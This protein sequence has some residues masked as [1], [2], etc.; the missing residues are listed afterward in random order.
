MMRGRLWK[1]GDHTFDLSQHGLIMGVLNVTPDSFSDGGNFFDT[2]DAAEH[3]LKMAAEGAHIVDV[4]GE[5]T[6]PGAEAVTAEEELRRVIPVIERLRRK[7]EVII[8]ID[9][10]KAEVARAAIRAGASIVNDVTGGRGDEG[11]MP[12]IAETKSALIIMH[13]QGTPRTMQIAPQ[14]SDVVSEISDF[15]RQQ[16]DRAIVYSIDPMAIAFDPGIGFGKTLEHN[17]ELLAH[18]EVLRACD[19]PIVIGVSRKSFLGKLINS[20][21]IGDRLAPAVALISLLRARG[22]DVFRVHDVT[23]NANALRVTEAILQRTK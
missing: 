12:L 15:F 16:Y 8:S 21:Q 1:I 22:A 17:L 9:T 6:R 19:R 13:M 11:M 18:L 5:S 10:S 4:G 20:A 23:E 3:G 7:S 14:Y 2:E